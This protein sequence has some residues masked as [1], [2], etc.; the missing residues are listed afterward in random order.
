MA[1]EWNPD[2]KY[3]P[4]AG[5]PAPM[6]VPSYSGFKPK[7]DGFEKLP[8]F[9]GIDFQTGKQVDLADYFKSPTFGIEGG[10]D[11]STSSPIGNLLDMQ[12]QIQAFEEAR[13]PFLTERYRKYGDIASRQ[14]LAQ[15][16]GLYPLLS[17]AGAE[18]TARS[19]A[20]SKEFL[21]A[22]QSAPSTIQDIMA[23]KQ[24]QMLQAAAGEAERQRA[25]ADQA[26]AAREF[27]GIRYAGQTFSVA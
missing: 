20:A 22:K 26:R 17:R 3:Q 19:L 7:K 9:K 8:S 18:A 4:M 12:R 13:E 6:E 1:V 21:A 14:Q 2:F 16:Y 10:Q 15:A 24:S 23:S 25:T 5:F 27:G 11:Q